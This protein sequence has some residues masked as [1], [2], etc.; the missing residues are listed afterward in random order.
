MLI[1]LAT[2]YPERAC[3]PDGKFVYKIDIGTGRQSSS[4]DIIRH[5]GAIYA[6]AMANRARPD[7]KVL[8]AMVRAAGFFAPKLR[9]TGRASRAVGRL[10]ETADRKP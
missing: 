2:D 3:G 10:V 1:Q 6:L 7:P 9:R 5:E 8:E 4:C